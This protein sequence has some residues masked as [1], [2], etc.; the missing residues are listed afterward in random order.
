VAR[1]AGGRAREPERERSGSIAKR[2]EKE[3]ER[4]AGERELQPPT[5]LL[6]D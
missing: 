4:K 6:S 5:F 3:K 1:C 2:V